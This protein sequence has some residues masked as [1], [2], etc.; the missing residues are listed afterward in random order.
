MQ[1]SIIKARIHMVIYKIQ[2]E[3][4]RACFIAYQTKNLTLK[5]FIPSFILVS[6]CLASYLVIESIVAYL[7]YEVI[8]TSREIYEASSLFPKITICNYNP[9][10]TRYSLEFLK[11]INEQI[12]PD[13]NMFNESQ[14]APLTYAQKTLLLSDIFL[15]ANLAMLRLSVE[16]KKLLGHSLE[17]ILISCTFNNEPCDAS[18]FAWKFDAFFGNCYVFNGGF[19]S[20]GHT[21][22]L[23]RS[24][25][26]GSLF[27]FNV[28]LYAD[29]HTNLTI[30]NA[31]Q[32]KG[33]YVRIE[34]SSY[35]SD[36]LL[37]NGI[38]ISPGKWTNALVKR[39][40]EFQL[41]RPYSSC[42]LKQNENVFKGKNSHLLNLMYHSPYEYNQQTC[43]ILC[44][45]HHAINTC[46]CT[47]PLYLSLFDKA[48]SCSTQSEL[49]CFDRG[50]KM[51]LEVNYVQVDY[52]FISGQ[53]FIV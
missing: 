14:F 19:N 26:A 31:N 38:Y 23:R 39:I 21:V 30:F 22:G 8:T 18:D 25:I 46:N 9:F 3:L 10:T 2:N 49:T 13:L 5:L 53:C 11:Q 48:K 47:Y 51:F 27:G 34:N 6:Y 28:Q 29:F 52:F 32:F 45:Q 50:W 41:P 17:D 20:S 12:R 15:A 35:L 4:I 1:N 7:S 42:D 37:D 16:E 36:D 44:I 40:F 33:A 24:Y 43:I